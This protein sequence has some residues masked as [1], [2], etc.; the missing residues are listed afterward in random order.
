DCCEN[1]IDIIV[2][3]SKHLKNTLRG[4]NPS[5][6]FDLQR[7]HPNTWDLWQNHKKTFIIETI[8]KNMEQ[9]IAEGLYRNDVNVEI[10]AILR[11]KEIELAFDIDVFPPQKFDLLSV[12]ITFLEHFI[13]GIVT[14]K[15]YAV[16]EDLFAKSQHNIF[17]NP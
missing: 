3:M 15:G 14:A 12:Q 17:Q 16:L 6:F 1:A 2:T 13:R 11:V 8:K 7:Y 10:L 5:L 9:G 4:I